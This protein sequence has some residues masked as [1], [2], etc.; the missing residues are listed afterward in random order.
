MA[1]ARGYCN[2]QAR[3]TKGQKEGDAARDDLIVC[4]DI[5]Y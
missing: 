5:S 4:V 1:V 3:D 2:V